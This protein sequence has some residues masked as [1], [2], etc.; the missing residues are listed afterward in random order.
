MPIKRPAQ[1]HD[2]PDHD[3]G[4]RHDSS[5]DNIGDAAAQCGFQYALVRQGCV[6][7]HGH[8]LRRIASPRDQAPGDL[9]QVLQRHVEDNHLSTLGECR[10]VQIIRHVTGSGMAGHKGHR[11]IDV[12][13]R[14]WNAGI[15]QTADPGRDPRHDT[16]RHAGRHQGASFFAG[17]A[18]HERVA[19]FEPQNAMALTGQLDQTQRD[20]RLL[21]RGLAATLAGIF[22]DSAGRSEAKNLIANEGIVDDG[23][24]FPQGMPGMQGQQP[25]IARAGT[26]Q[27]D[28]AGLE[29]RYRYWKSI[30]ERTIAQRATRSLVR[31]RHRAGAGSSRSLYLDGMRQDE[32]SA[33]KR[34]WTTG[35][36]ATAATKAAYT[37]LLTGRFPDPVSIRLPGGQ[38]PAFALARESLSGD[39]A[40]AGIVKDAGDDPDVTH[41]ALVLVTVRAEAAGNGII[42]NAGEGVGRVTRAGLP[43]AVGEP[44]INPVPRQMMSTIVQDL[45]AEHGR[46]PDLRIEI[47]IPGGEELARRTMNGRLGIVGGLS[48]LGTTGI[49]VPF[50]CAAWIASIHRGIDVA[51]A[52]GLTHI[53]AATGSTSEAAVQS[54]YG[55]PE[56]ALIDMGDFAGGTLKYL[57]QHSVPRLSLAGGFA[58]ICKL[59]QGNL[60]LHSG[61]SQ[62]DMD[63]LAERLRRLGAPP[64]AVANA[65]TANSALAVLQSSQTLGLPLADRVA[66]E[67]RQL[68]ESVAGPEVAVE[69]MIFDRAGTLV[70]RS[71]GQEP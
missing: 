18:E 14:Q 40:T 46:L 12:A 41:G 45:A 23:V 8:R 61:R 35:A 51:R 52:A 25:G 48:I 56:I 62:V 17:T 42:F 69:V 19:T 34:G 32:T 64:E 39:S 36:C 29:F 26:N 31:M 16:K 15:G 7:H 33:L 22:K 20:I 68:C 28:P 70:G 1:R 47:A 71:N 27:P 49:V 13:M 4:R 37:A 67:A 60:D 3:N 57:R 21:R 63:W 38:S 30:H 11:G 43:L 9:F 24:G 6:G 65:Q 54:Y 2:I 10:P 55:L 50:S 59:A 66:M 44:A 53:A 58:K 5:G